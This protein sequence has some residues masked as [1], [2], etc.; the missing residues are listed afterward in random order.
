VPPR[1]PPTDRVQLDPLMASG[2]KSEFEDSMHKQIKNAANTTPCLLLQI[3]K[4][5]LVNML[6]YELERHRRRL[7]AITRQVL[8]VNNNAVHS[9]SHVGVS[10]FD[11][12][13][14]P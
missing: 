10:P 6:H 12:R 13:L 4:D 11:L 2:V 9:P 8:S 3:G 7:I 5:S 1:F 14:S